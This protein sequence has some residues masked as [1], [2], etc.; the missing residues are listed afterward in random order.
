MINK[1]L[2]SFTLLLPFIYG[3]T[4]AKVNKL[5]DSEIE[6][7]KTLSDLY[8]DKLVAN[9]F[10][11]D[12]SNIR[13]VPLV[14]P[15]TYAKDYCEHYKGHFVRLENSPPLRVPAHPK[16]PQDSTYIKDLEVINTAFGVFQCEWMHDEPKWRVYITHK[17]TV[18][19]TPSW[20]TTNVNVKVL[21]FA[22]LTK[23]IYAQKEQERLNGIQQLKKEELEKRLQK[24]AKVKENARRVQAMADINALRAN[25]NKGVTGVKTNCGPVLETKG[26]LVKVYFGVKDY[27]NEHWIDVDRLFTSNYECRFIGGEYFP[28]TK[29]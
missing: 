16:S 21:E 12:Y 20:N 28:P 10:L 18:S 29:L 6:S 19:K 17:N 25:I 13:Y 9:D 24:E 23:L 27:G 3:C 5:S 2:L 4:A 14:E 26:T 8:A 11:V 1:K 7:Y 22:E 15:F